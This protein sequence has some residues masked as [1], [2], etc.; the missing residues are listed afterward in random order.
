MARDSPLQMN[1]SQTPEIKAVLEELHTCRAPIPS[2][3]MAF[4]FQEPWQNCFI[5]IA[6]L[7]QNTSSKKLSKVNASLTARRMEIIWIHRS[8]G[9]ENTQPTVHVHPEFA[10]SE[11]G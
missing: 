4:H 3:S 6:S 1:V 2:C 9:G 10:I 7:G 11:V 5:A 8:H